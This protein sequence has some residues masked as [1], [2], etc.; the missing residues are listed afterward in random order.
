MTP[1]SLYLAV[2]TAALAAALASP[3]DPPPLSPDNDIPGGY[4]GSEDLRGSEPDDGQNRV[5][6]GSILFSLGALRLG[7]GVF[8]YVSAT[9]QYCAQVYGMS[10]ADKTCSGLRV[11]GLVG[12]GLGGLM[13]VTG[14]VILALGLM[15]RQRHREWLQGRS[16]SLGPWLG[17]QQHGVAFGFRF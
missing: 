1:V 8:G 6:L 3:A 4:L 9:P 15:Q 14:A 5:T 16:V 13:T 11:Y 12:T 17:P 10:V 2:R 7:A